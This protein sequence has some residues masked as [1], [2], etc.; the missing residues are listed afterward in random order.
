MSRNPLAIGKT[1]N[2]YLIKGVYDGDYEINDNMYVMDFNKGTF[3][4]KEI[5]YSQK[6]YNG[7]I[8]INGKKISHKVAARLRPSLASKDQDFC[9][10][11]TGAGAKIVA[12]AIC[13]EILKYNEWA[14]NVYQIFAEKYIY[15]LKRENFEIEIDLSDFFIDNREKLTYDYF[16]RYFEFSGGSREIALVKNA[17]SNMFSVD[18]LDEVTWAYVERQ[19]FSYNW[20]MPSLKSFFGK[21]DNEPDHDKPPF[22]R[23]A[24]FKKNRVILQRQ[25]FTKK[26]SRLKNTCSVMLQTQIHYVLSLFSYKRDE[27]LRERAIRKQTILKRKKEKLLSGIAK[28][29]GNK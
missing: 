2:K 3:E 16:T 18:L 12:L 22:D 4:K 26:Y 15:S 11:N 28:K 14:L 9:W 29:K 10:G 24:A 17:S 1:S 13:Q 8:W 7:T 6:S 19:E 20:K 25:F 5:Y 21:I 23:I 27:N